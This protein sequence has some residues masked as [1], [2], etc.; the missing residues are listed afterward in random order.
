MH[1]CFRKD[2]VSVSCSSSHLGR[3]S[4]EQF[5]F[6][7][8]QASEHHSGTH[9]HTFYFPRDKVGQLADLF[10]AIAPKLNRWLRS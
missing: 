1:L 4:Q 2:K 8:S 9:N 10:P 6:L 5:D 7:V 3:F